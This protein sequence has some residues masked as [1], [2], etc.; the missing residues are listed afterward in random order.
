MGIYMHFWMLHNCTQQHVGF[1][2]TTFLLSGYCCSLLLEMEME[3]RM[4]FPIYC[5]ACFSVDSE[6]SNLVYFSH[7][8]SCCTR[9]PLGVS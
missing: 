3:I 6:T 4:C 1:I 7:F 5:M 8:L 9:V 2:E